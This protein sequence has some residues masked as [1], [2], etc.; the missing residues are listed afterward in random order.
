[1]EASESPPGWIWGPAQPLDTYTVDGLPHCVGS[2]SWCGRFRPLPVPLLLWP[3]TRK[4]P[5]DPPP[6]LDPPGSGTL[7]TDVVLAGSTGVGL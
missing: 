5:P 3:A 1:M 4:L 7:L 6:A 2:R